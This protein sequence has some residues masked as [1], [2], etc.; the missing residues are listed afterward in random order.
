MTVKC[1]KNK[2]YLFITIGKTYEVSYIYPYDYRII[3]DKGNED[4]YSKKCFK[5]LSEIRNETINKLLR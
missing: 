5:P 2:G 1:I 3:N 4:W